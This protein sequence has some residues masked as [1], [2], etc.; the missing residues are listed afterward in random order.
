MIYY[1]CHYVVGVQ[2]G[3]TREEN[4]RNRCNNK[5]PLNNNEIHNI[6]FSPQT[7]NDNNNIMSDHLID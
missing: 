4:S 1:Q 5:F 3:L 7:P 2:I 6:E